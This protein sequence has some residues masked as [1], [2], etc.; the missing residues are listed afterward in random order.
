MVWLIIIGFIG[1]FAALF[2]VLDYLD[3][4]REWR[5][6]LPLIPILLSFWGLSLFAYN[7]YLDHQRGVCSKWGTETNYETKYVN[8]GYGNWDCYG[9]VEAKWVPTDRI[10]GV[11]NE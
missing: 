5:Y 8:T 7:R 4:A 11:E 2:A 10:R 3:Y 9:L 1:L 6:A